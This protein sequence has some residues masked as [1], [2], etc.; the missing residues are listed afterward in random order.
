MRLRDAVDMLADSGV[1][2]LGPTRW[3][4]LCRGTGTFTLA[5]ASLL[6]E[7]STIHA[8]DRDASALRRIP[9]AHNHVRI[10][11]HRGDFT[12]HAWPFTNLDGI[13]MANSLHYVSEQEKFISSCAPRMIVPRRFLIVEYDTTEANRWIP[14]PVGRARVKD[15]F[16]AAGYSSLRLLRS[17]PSMF[18]RATLYAALM[19]TP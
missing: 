1:T 16:A 18:R 15:L 17:R 14:H 12:S 13:L 3:A 10:T 9:S 11:T 6:A 5:L 8:M 2:A 4:D 7:G 19:E